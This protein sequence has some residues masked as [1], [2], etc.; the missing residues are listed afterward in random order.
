MILQALGYPTEFIK[1][2]NLLYRYTVY[3]PQEQMKQIVLEDA[4]TRLNT[5]R[6]I[7]GID[8]YKRIKENLG[9]LLIRLKEDAKLFQG[10]INTLDEDKLKFDLKKELLKNLE[11][12]IK[13][14]NEELK[15][16]ISKSK[17]IES[18]LQKLEDKIQEKEYLEKK[19]DRTK[20]LLSTKYENLSGVNFEIIELRK[21]LLES[22]EEF[23]ESEY[24]IILLNLVIMK[25]RIIK[26]EKLKIFF[27]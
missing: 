27:Q 5:L 11:K 25:I 18:Q 24:K 15:I 1:K 4:E 26:K 20:V 14:K 2:N 8:K 23:N 19:L 21:N 17:E 9:I 7:L 3:T 6:Y 10:E 13:E 22:G 16:R 12:R